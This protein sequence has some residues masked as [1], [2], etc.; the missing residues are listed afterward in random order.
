VK[1]QLTSLD[2]FYLVKELQGL[3]S[4]RVQK[5]YQIQ[6]TVY[7]V[8]YGEQTKQ[9]IVLAPNR[10]TVTEYEHKFPVKPP[11]FC[12]LLR[13]H[14]VNKRIVSIT[15]HE[16]ERIVEIEFPDRILVVELF[17]DG[18]I[19][20]V[21][22]NIHE[23]IQPLHV[24]HW[25]ARNIV[26][27]NVYEYPPK[28]VNTPELTKEAFV[29]ILKTSDKDVVRT[30][31]TKLSLGGTYAEEVCFLTDVNKET[32]GSVLSD[33]VLN[34]IYARAKEL[35]TKEVKP[36]V[37]EKQQVVAP[38]ELRHL[39]NEPKPFKSITEAADAFFAEPVIK[40]DKHDEL[41]HRLDEQQASLTKIKKDQ[42]EY[43]KKGDELSQKQNFK[44]AGEAYEKGKK[45]KKKETGLKGAIENTKKQ[46]EKTPVVI[47]KPKK[48]V[49]EKKEW[50]EKFRW[51]NSS[52]GFL[53]VGGKDATTNEMIVKKYTEKNDIVFHAEIV[54]APFCVVKARK[55][56]G[57]KAK[58]IPE[59][60]LEEAAQFAAS[61]SKAWQKKLGTIDVY[62]VKPEQLRKELGL[63]KGAFMVHGERDYYHNV[64][65]EMA[66]S[67]GKKKELIH[68]PSKMVE[69]QT[70]R[71]VRVRPGRI[72]AG[73]LAKKIKHKLKFEGTIEDIQKFI[74]TGKGVLK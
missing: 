54:G 19:I 42:T 6:N 52:D 33:E 23:I 43:K 49:V 31:A 62:A 44:E 41:K 63:P 27:K 17:S 66:F 2:L 73:E 30:L 9:T 36:S 74:P 71:L 13:K 4:A 58:K 16:F 15:Q 5:V 1:K 3:V 47:E 45:A 32:L 69:K 11:N 37:Y 7:L 21:D 55:R 26:P 53:I 29:E 20:L 28:G 68:G 67:L 35:F 57:A 14:L 18:N 51:F 72:R 48:K 59:T 12:M 60:T 70:K 25:K 8:V 10:I 61:Y 50:Y 46:L 65:L 22:K 56:E 34:R 40:R 38:F 64:V 24:Q 39:E